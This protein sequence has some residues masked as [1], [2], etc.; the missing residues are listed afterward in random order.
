MIG[1]DLASAVRARWAIGL[2]AGLCLGV[3]LFVGVVTGHTGWGAIASMGGFAGFYG[4]LAPYRH[5]AR[6]VVTVGFALTIVVPIGSLCASDA[7]LAIPFVG[8]VAGAASFAGL[9]LGVPPP[10][11]YLV[12]L[13]ALA[14]TGIPADVAGAGRECWLVAAGGG[15]AALLTL[16]PAFDRRRRAPQAKAVAA[17]W[18]TV[19]S[20]LRSAGT[21]AAEQ[22]RTRAVAETRTALEVLRQARV[23]EADHELRSVAAAETVLAGALSLSI[24]TTKP[25]RP[26]LIEAVQNL[27]TAAT[28]GTAAHVDAE[29][30]D[31]DPPELAEVIAAARAVVAGE[32]FDTQ[33]TPPERPA[34]LRRL[35]AALRPAAGV[36]PVAGRMS[37]TVAAGAGVGRTLGLPHAYWVGLT[38]AAVLQAGNLRLVLR[39]AA[40]RLAGT[41][42][43]V[44]LAGLILTLRPTASIVAVIATLAQVVAE[45]V[46]RASYAVAMV[47][48]T[49]IALSV[50]DL[51]AP[52][53]HL[54]SAVGARVVDT[55]IGIAVVTL[56]RLVLWPQASAARLPDAQAATLRAVADVFRLRWIGDPMHSGPVARRHLAECLLVLQ[57]LADDLRAD[58]LVGSRSA[59]TEGITVPV[60]ELAMLALGVPYDRDGPAP[61]HA[62]ALTELLDRLA[63]SVMDGSGLAPGAVPDLP[64][65]PRTRAATELLVS[66]LC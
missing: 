64:G 41:I 58:D 48:I 10:R 40:H 29:A 45:T 63:D 57:T 42:V 34:V 4:P 16:A 1:G 12:I 51:A 60:E 17:A 25:L 43:G 8:M 47:F 6:L 49:V 37:I 19:V 28:A 15:S 22:S 27:A 52:G 38:C 26:D 61:A 55:A 13:A 31:T 21:S 5:R 59:L 14:S 24:E 62:T 11:E 18:A 36:I 20:V 33:V 9:A 56:L 66:A 35:T 7:W 54:G 3:P 50:Y 44:L 46:I 39:R 53:A 30:R 32:D 23:G 65:Y 2:R